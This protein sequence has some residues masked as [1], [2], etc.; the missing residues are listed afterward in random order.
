MNGAF[1]ALVSLD[2]GAVLDGVHGNAAADPFARPGVAV[3]LHVLGVEVLHWGWRK[4]RGMEEEEASFL[5]LLVLDARHL[6]PLHSIT[7]SSISARC[8][9]S[10][11]PGFPLLSPTA[12]RHGSRAWRR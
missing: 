6:P 2:G 12:W 11:T 10:D 9:V 3:A 4:K 8:R 1:I 5:V 7:L